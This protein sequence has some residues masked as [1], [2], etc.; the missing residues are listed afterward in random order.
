MRKAVTA[1]LEVEQFSR[2]EAE[3]ACRGVSPV[4]LARQLLAKG[5]PAAAT[6]IDAET[7][8]HAVAWSALSERSFARDWSYDG[9][10]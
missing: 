3:A 7:S 8:A 4:E 5:L 10:S 9:V 1:E 6:D 2:L